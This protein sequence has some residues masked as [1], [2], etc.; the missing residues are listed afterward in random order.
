MDHPAERIL[1][2][3]KVLAALEELHPHFNNDEKETR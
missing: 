3:E 1:L 2:L